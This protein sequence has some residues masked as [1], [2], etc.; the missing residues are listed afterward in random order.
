MDRSYFRTRPWRLLNLARAG[1]RP[2]AGKR[3]GIASDADPVLAGIPHDPIEPR[4]ESMKT[5]PSLQSRVRWAFA[6]LPLFV[7]TLLVTSFLAGCVTLRPASRDEALRY[8]ELVNIGDVVACE[9]RAGVSRTF[10]V[11]A[12]QSGWLIGESDSVYLG[13]VVRLEIRRGSVERAAPLVAGVAWVAAV[14]YLVA[15]PPVFLP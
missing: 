9:M 1:L 12:V 11:D 8:A 15:H 7:V 14:G 6:R 2:V 13:D 5:S 3:V 10:R 4:H